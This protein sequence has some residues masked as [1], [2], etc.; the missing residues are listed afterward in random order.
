M[1]KM[2]YDCGKSSIGEG[3]RNTGQVW[4]GK[5]VERGLGE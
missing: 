4:V 3:N 1:L 2:L 5:R